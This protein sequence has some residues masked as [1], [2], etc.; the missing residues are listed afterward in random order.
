MTEH[1]EKPAG[2][3]VSNW[4]FPKMPASHLSSEGDESNKG[5]DSLARSGNCKPVINLIS[6]FT[7]VE[8]PAK[9]TH[10]FL[11]EG[12][13]HVCIT[14]TL[15]QTQRLQLKRDDSDCGHGI[16]R[17]SSQHQISNLIQVSSAWYPSSIWKSLTCFHQRKS[18]KHFPCHKFPFS[19]TSE[20]Y[21]GSSAEVGHHLQLNT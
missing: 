20:N 3:R 8:E 19:A 21:F 7:K 17:S 6:K 15:L 11:K 5:F 14:S 2:S 9:H 16:G 13:F 1:G 10:K 4:H 18:V 12:K